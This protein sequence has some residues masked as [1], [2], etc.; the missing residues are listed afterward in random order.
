[1][2]ASGYDR[3]RRER[4]TSGG[5]PVPGLWQRR[6][7]DGTIAYVARLGPRGAERAVTLE[8]RTKT[9][10]IRE[11]QAL[12][13]D[14]DRGEMRG[15]LCPTIAELAE[16]WLEHLQARVGITD[17]RRRYSQGTV[18]MYRQRLEAHVLERLGGTRVDEL[19]VDELRR[20]VDRLTRK[21]L[22]PSTVT[23]CVN[24][25]SG[26]MRYAV[27]RGLAPHNPVRDLDR[28]DRPGTARQTEP[29]YL[30]AAEL[31]LLLRA[32]GETFRPVA[33]VCAYAGLRASEALGLR[34]ADVDLKAGTIT[35]SGQLD[36]RG[37]RLEQTKTAASAAT[38]P[39]LPALR[40]QLI[41][42]RTRSGARGLGRLQADQLVFVTATGRSHGRRNL[43]RAIQQAA[44]RAGLEQLGTHDLRH[45]FVGLAF[46]HGLT[47]PEVSELA[48]HANPRVT[49]TMY[50]GL[51]ADGRERAL[52]KLAGGFGA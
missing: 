11:N 2:T 6:R 18:D 1:M 27:K 13:V 48:R 47:P 35:V 22:A 52:A 29:R 38:V 21:G 12:R 23:S 7:P 36:R 16:A 51:T 41:E 25:T 37:G 24:I 31:E 9:D 26:L 39:M 40:R 5:R 4:V 3:A 15:G 49:L 19:S 28:D 30:T 44:T 50:A 43:L 33:A 14:H 42:H 20:M 10:A 45:S 8:A 46:E 32:M 17:V 34:W